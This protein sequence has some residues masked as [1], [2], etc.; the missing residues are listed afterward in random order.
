[1]RTSKHSRASSRDEYATIKKKKRSSAKEKYFGLGGLSAA[2]AGGRHTQCFK[3]NCSCPRCHG[4]Y[5]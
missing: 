5:R 3:L 2:C 1:M 4:A